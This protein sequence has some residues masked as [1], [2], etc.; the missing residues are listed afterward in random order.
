MV[1]NGIMELGG[2]GAGGCLPGLSHNVHIHSIVVKRDD[3]P[4]QLVMYTWLVGLSFLPL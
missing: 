4:Q 1:R 2:M 3:T